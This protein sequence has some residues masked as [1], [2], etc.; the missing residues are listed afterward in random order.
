M[1]YITTECYLALPLCSWGYC[2]FRIVTQKD[3]LSSFFPLHYFWAAKDNV[4]GCIIVYARLSQCF[5]FFFSRNICS[6]KSPN[7]SGKSINFIC[8]AQAYIHHWEHGHEKVR[9]WYFVFFIQ[10]SSLLLAS[11][12]FLF[13]HIHSYVLC[14]IRVE[15]DGPRSSSFQGIQQI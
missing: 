9:L 7:Q 15:R 13:M 8:E 1:N 6:I 12:D 10:D 2:G 3:Y 11:L 4:Y 14:S 5:F